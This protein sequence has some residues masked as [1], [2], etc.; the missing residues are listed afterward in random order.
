MTDQLGAQPAPNSPSLPLG[1]RVLWLL[2]GAIATF[3]MFLILD[4][5]YPREPRVEPRPVVDFDLNARGG[6][7]L[8]ALTRKNVPSTN[9]GITPVKRHL[10]IILDGLVL[11][12]PTVNSEVSSKGRIDGNFLE[13]EIDSL[14]N[15]LNAGATKSKQPD[16]RDVTTKETN[17]IKRRLSKVGLLEF[18]ILANSAD[19][20]AAIEDVMKLINHATPEVNK[21]LEEAQLNGLLPPVPQTEGLKGT[22]KVYDLTLA[23]GA[24]SRVTYSW[25]E[26]GPPELRFN[27]PVWDDAAKAIGKATTLFSAFD[28]MKYME[29]A[30]FF[31]RPCK[32]RNLSEKELK[33]K[34]LEY[35]V[36]A[37][38]PE[39]DA[40]T[41]KETPRVDSSYLVTPLRRYS[42]G[43][44]SLEAY[45][46][47]GVLAALGGLLWFVRR[48]VH[49]PCE[50]L[51][52]HCV[53]LVIT[54][55]V[56]L[57]A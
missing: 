41:G 46:V 52:G 4:R 45:V 31:C 12:V 25:V 3:V 57:A 21:T 36:L 29:G 18:R 53:A 30:L 5:N 23:K 37:R 35:F 11:S 14:V 20:Q 27:Q 26:L 51:I 47:L 7:L 33:E 24:K 28:G 22:P 8:A 39:I 43:E 54:L 42:H 15:I 13:E 38:N 2:V 40:A 50:F 9:D 17:G 34:R 55:I 32:D 6:E 10:A 19:D 44:K 1:R 48:W 16:S 49:V 56:I